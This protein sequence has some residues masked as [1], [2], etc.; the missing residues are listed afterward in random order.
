M[1]G[2]VTKKLF[3]GFSRTEFRILG[4]LSKLDKFLSNPQMRTFTGT[5]PV[6][7]RNNDVENH[8]PSGDRSQKDL[9]PEV[10]FFA[11]CS[12]NPTDSD[13]DET[14]HMKTRVQRRIPYCS[15]G[16]YSGKQKE[17]RSTSQPQFCSEN[18]P[19]TIEADQILLALQQLVT[20]K[21][22]ANVNN[23]SNRISKLPK[24]LTKTMLPFDGKT[25][26]F[27]L[28]EDLFQ[29]SLKI[30]NELAE[31]DKIKYFHSLMRGDALQTFKNTGN[32]NRESDRNPD[33]VP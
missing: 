15:L 20:N 1:R 16:T 14:S 7:F 2:G 9:H 18:T 30:D 27:E 32:R 12:S 19:A 3:Q 10:G 4:A 22:S 21:N 8:E 6:T 24:P 33:C 29:V 26:K 11:Y 23:N 17:A 5:T 31:E 25:E 28:F 13:P